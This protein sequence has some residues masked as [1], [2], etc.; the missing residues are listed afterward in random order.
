MYNKPAG[1]L[2]HFRVAVILERMS[3]AH[4]AGMTAAD[5][6]RHLATMYNMDRD[7]IQNV[8]VLLI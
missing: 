3:R 1:M 4:V 7:P 6:W 5:L 2:K 8:K